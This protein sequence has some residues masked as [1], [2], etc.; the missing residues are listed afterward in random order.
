MMKC[1]LLAAGALALGF[2]VPA[3]AQDASTSDEGVFA[4]NYLA[5]GVGAGVLP[6]Y[7]GSNDYNISPVPLVQGRLWGIGINP[8]PRHTPSRAAVSR[9]VHRSRWARP[10]EGGPAPAS[11]RH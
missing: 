10:I 4:G 5:V 9:A 8:R 11:A 7:E 1:A 6:T 2:A 3:A